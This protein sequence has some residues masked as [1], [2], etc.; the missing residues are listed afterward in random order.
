MATAEL[1]WGS[2][3]PNGPPATA[4]RPHIHGIGLGGRSVSIDKGLGFRR[5]TA[6][7]LDRGDPIKDG[8]SFRFG[9][10]AT[11]EH[12]AAL[13]LAGGFLVRLRSQWK[14]FA[15]SLGAFALSLGLTERSLHR[16]H[17]I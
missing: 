5:T 15:L 4:G 1:G 10:W 7:Q 14:G 3:T 16:L 9:S 17:A 8:S 6:V 12:Q 2:Y 11:E 13:V